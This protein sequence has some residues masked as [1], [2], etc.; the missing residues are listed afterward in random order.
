MATGSIVDQLRLALPALI[1]FIPFVMGQWRWTSD[2][3]NTTMCYWEQL[4][5]KSSVISAGW[6]IFTD[7]QLTCIAAIVNDTVY[8]DGGRL[9]WLPGLADGQYDA[10][11]DD[12][13]SSHSTL[14]PYRPD[15]DQRI[16]VGLSMLSTSVFPST[17]RRMPQLCSGLRNSQ[18][19]RMPGQQTI[20]VLTT[21]TAPCLQTT[22]N[23]SSMGAC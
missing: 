3:V 10:V 14:H 9:W 15:G 21:T 13:K 11:V 7:K 12:R 19:H 4:R 2:Q 18:K 20:G 23:S 6:W 17:Q 1:C 22:T 16:L 8:L 5:G